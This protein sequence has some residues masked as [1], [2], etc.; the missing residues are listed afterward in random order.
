M[1]TLFKSSSFLDNA[2]KESRLLNLAAAFLFLYALILTLAPAVR[3][4]TLQTALNW[5][6]WMGFA[7]WAAGAWWVR[8]ALQTYL[9]DHDPYLLPLGALLSGWGLLTVWRLDASLGLRQMLWLGFGWLL[10]GMGVR[11]PNLLL[12]L[13]RYK[14]VWLALGLLLVALTLVFGTYPAGEGPGLWLGCCGFYLQPAEPLKI[15]LLIYLAAY[16]AERL[17][18]SFDLTSL[19]AP[20]LVVVGI[21]VALL[22]IQR[23][24]GTASLLLIL[25]TLVLYLATGKRRI[26]LFTLAGLILAAW[27]G[28]AVFGLIHG[29][30]LAWWDPWSQAGGVGYQIIQSL[31]AVAE[32]GLLGTGP[33]LGSPGFVPVAHSDFIAVAITEETG[34]LGL[35]G[36]LGLIGLLVTRSFI[37]AVR[38][39]NLYRRLLAA[40]LGVY[41]G[42]QSA[43]IIGGNLRLF[44][45]TGVTLP[46]VSYGGSSLIVS[47]VA[48]LFLLQ[49]SATEETMVTPVTAVQPFRVVGGGFLGL[50]ALLAVLGGWWGLIRGEALRNRADNLRWV[51]AERFVPRGQILDRQENV[52][53]QSEGQAGNYRR[54][55]LYPPLASTLGFI[56]PQLGKTGLEAGLDGYLRGW[57][58]QPAWNILLARLLY[59]QPPQGLDVRLTL[60]LE[61]QRAADTAMTG[62]QGALVILNAQSGEILA[63]V[64]QPSYD[65]NRLDED[66]ERWKADPRAP[67]LN[68]V[69]QGQ[70]PPGTALTP[71]LW[72]I[73][74]LSPE[75]TDTS[76]QSL[77]LQTAQGRFPCARTPALPLNWASA[78]QAGCPW[79]T[80]A[81][82]QGLSGE[83]LSALGSELGWGTPIQLPLPIAKASLP[84]ADASLESLITGEA[85][86]YLSP[87]QMAQ[88]V[89][90][91]QQGLRPDIHLVGAVKS[92]QQEWIVLP[93]GSGT[94]VELAGRR[95]QQLEAWADSNLP[96]WM[97][98]GRGQ[99]GNKAVV[100]VLA[101]TVPSWQGSPLVVVLALEEGTAE[102]GEQIVREVLTVAL[103]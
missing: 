83:Q 53:V 73:Q 56:H 98:F 37:V 34:L 1:N 41:L 12:W 64:S 26:L 62:K 4:H 17:P 25:Y 30:L 16:L 63:M 77:A 3:V 7:V 14:Y 65:P 21:A 11:W 46:F 87:L 74:R 85:G 15:L 10:L 89:A 39:P 58:G 70:Y 82:A 69:T 93:V 22:V 35:V 48:L 67:L 19:I 38:A 103:R 9:G 96:I 50:L 29:R 68:R 102:E 33:G 80:L 101:G 79:V 52:L 59:A 13:R 28:G 92:P 5:R 20:T 47:F 75:Q 71:F 18:F 32:G 95:V 23:D 88:A 94:K 24:L 57:V 78:A 97:A 100:W 44:P 66:W 31:I 45:L 51:V 42:G 91:L 86:W 2:I 72:G 90:V 40:G 54:V 8:R 76:P 49:I 55:V 60:S 6:H 27:V 61:L 43:L 36:L 81:L 84:P 99:S